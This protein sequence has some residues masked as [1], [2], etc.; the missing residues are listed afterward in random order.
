[1]C[2]SLMF[3]LA[4]FSSVSRKGNLVSGLVQYPGAVGD[5]TVVNTRWCQHGEI[6]R[7][8]PLFTSVFYNLRDRQMQMPSLFEQ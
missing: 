1:M 3:L 6:C 2:V 5:K 7:K 4:K 8:T